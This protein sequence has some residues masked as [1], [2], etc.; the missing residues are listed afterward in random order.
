MLESDEYNVMLN[1]II[2]GTGNF[3]LGTTDAEFLL[4]G[5]YNQTDH[6]LVGKFT[7]IATPENEFLYYAVGNYDPQTPTSG[8]MKFRL[9][10]ANLENDI[11]IFWYGNYS[12][13]T[14]MWCC[15]Y[16]G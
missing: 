7:N 14:W 5:K 16:Y 11:G 9:Y 6:T 12:A 4:W 13:G 3:L 1:P 10:N 2:A 8:N 15:F